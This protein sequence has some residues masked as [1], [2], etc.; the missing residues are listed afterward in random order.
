MNR[1]LVTLA[2]VL[3]VGN[4]CSAQSDKSKLELFTSYL[5]ATTP[6]VQGSIPLRT[7]QAIITQADRIVTANE[8]KA[9]T[10]RELRVASLNL[11]TC[12]TSELSRLDRDLG[13][14]LYGEVMS[15]RGRRERGVESAPVAGIQITGM[16]K[17]PQGLWVIHVVNQSHKEIETIEFSQGCC[18]KVVFNPDPSFA[19]GAEKEFTVGDSG[20]E[21]ATPPFVGVVVYSDPTT[22]ELTAEV[23]D[24][25]ALQTIEQHRADA[26]LTLQLANGIL[27][28]HKN[29][30]ETVKDLETLAATQTS[31]RTEKPRP[32]PTNLREMARELREGIISADDL[33]AQNAKAIPHLE[34][35][36]RRLP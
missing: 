8:L 24:E 5:G 1:I 23:M 30:E 20:E 16:E 14:G 13:V 19:A 25:Q 34:Q 36:I 27:A 17:N 4:I 11:R 31:H 22:G 26:L 10:E 15:E 2:T 9:A 35:Q 6:P 32:D 29:T 7:C 21:N 3:C 33:S 18:S 12:A 28:K